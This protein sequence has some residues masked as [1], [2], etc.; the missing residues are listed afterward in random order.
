MCQI[1]DSDT[2]GGSS[3]DTLAQARGA[4]LGYFYIATFYK[5]CFYRAYIESR[6][7]KYPFLV[8]SEGFSSLID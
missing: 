5:I 7:Q 6:Y 2:T 1:L 3:G 8:E 4:R